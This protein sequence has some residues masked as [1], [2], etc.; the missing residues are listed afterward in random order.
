MAIYDI[1]N[2][3]FHLASGI[4][5]ENF[6]KMSYSQIIGEKGLLAKGKKQTN[7]EKDYDFSFESW[8]FEDI[9]SFPTDNG[10][11][12]FYCGKTPFFSDDTKSLAELL[13]GNKVFEAGY[14]VISA[15]TQSLKENQSV[16]EI[17]AGGIFLDFVENGSVNI[18]FLPK[19]V[20]E[21]SVAGLSLEEKSAL[22]ES[23]I[24]PSLNL[25]G[26]LK[27]LSFIRGSIAYKM[28]TGR[29]AFPALNSIERNAD[30]LDGKFLPVELSVN[31]IS[32]ELASEINDALMLNSVAVVIPGKKEKKSRKRVVSAKADFPLE[33]LYNSKNLKCETNL[34]DDEFKARAESFLK[35]QESKVNTKRKMRRNVSLIVTS[36][37]VLITLGLIIGNT[38]KS[39]GSNV[40]SRGLTAEETVEAFFMAV[41]KLDTSMMSALSKGKSAGRYND[42]VSQV[43]VIS[44]NRQAY[45]GHDKGIMNPSAFFLYLGSESDL[46]DG[47]LYGITNL[48]ISGKDKYMDLKLAEKRTKPDPITEDKGVKV[49]NRMHSVQKVEYD[50]IHT[51]GPERE[52]FGEHHTDIITLTFN[53]DRW[54]VTDVKSE[55]N[56]I[57]INN[58]QFMK[59]YDE[60]FKMMDKDN[61]AVI[62]VLKNRY[63]WLPSEKEMQNEIAEQ[64]AKKIEMLKTY[65]QF[66][67]EDLK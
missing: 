46:M 31:G 65:G 62:R 52:I 36:A 37:I 23:W 53:K 29:V 59:D 14:V 48:K 38:I 1:K 39:N 61:A 12:V 19:G 56:D 22:Q 50:I 66:I 44:K 10:Q 67:P 43:Y 7:S 27:A 30:I 42:M 11:M 35:R 24:N 9:Q 64:K 33:L 45:G 58:R 20:Y 57:N 41:N 26:G 13:D 16:P 55:Q 25:L 17:G 4:L 3:N 63:S 40:T 34:S 51:E 49:E 28:L 8:S 32:E 47:A 60:L 2:N 18:L 21:V 15:I 5:E 54:I 6:G